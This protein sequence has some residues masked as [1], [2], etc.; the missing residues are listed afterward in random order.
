VKHRNHKIIYLLYIL[1]AFT[2]LCT[3]C[4][5]GIVPIFPTITITVGPTS[6]TISIEG[7]AETTFNRTPELTLYSEGAAYMSFSGD[8]I[9]WSEW[10][11]Y[12]TFYED[13]N[14]ANNLYGTELSSGPKYVYVRF[15]DENEKLSPPDNL[16]F[17]TIN[18]QLKDLNSIKIIP[19]EITMTIGSSYTFEVKGYDIDSNEIPLDGSQII[20]EK[21]CGVGSLS[22]TSGLTTTYTAPTVTGDRDIIANCGPLRAG[23]KIIVVNK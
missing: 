20:W 7:G 22:D 5:G 3:G 1:I 14:I 6:G 18:Y 16:T 10:I 12:N 13:F 8:G 11:E 15:K 17:D 21:S 9:N 23:A 4:T 19:S 2:I